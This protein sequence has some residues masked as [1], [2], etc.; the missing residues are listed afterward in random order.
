M[1]ASS[2][3][4]A[5]M[6]ASEPTNGLS[7]DHAEPRKKLSKRNEPPPELIGIAGRPGRL[8]DGGQFLK[9]SRNAESLFYELVHQADRTLFSSSVFPFRPLPF[10]CFRGHSPFI[11]SDL[12]PISCLRIYVTHMF[13]LTFFVFI[14][15]H[16]S[17]FLL[18]LIFAPSSC[19][20]CLVF[21]LSTDVVD[22]CEIVEQ[23]QQV[24]LF[25]ER[26]VGLRLSSQSTW[27]RSQKLK[28]P[29]R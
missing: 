10:C 1:L 24:S 19:F 18:T 12:L 8:V 5:T 9:P 27:A 28:F 4:D 3:A 14:C 7:G 22:L 26:C 2:A 20:I 16:L 29:C 11:S 13:F 21:F 17:A 6:S 15:L 25:L 23:I